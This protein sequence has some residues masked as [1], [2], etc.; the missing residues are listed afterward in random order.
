MCGSCNGAGPHLSPIN[1]IKQPDVISDVL[2]VTEDDI[3][4]SMANNPLPVPGADTYPDA[5]CRLAYED[6]AT[7]RATP[8]ITSRALEVPAGT[9]VRVGKAIVLDGDRFSSGA[10]KGEVYRLEG[11]PQ[12]L[13][14]VV[15]VTPDGDTIKVKLIARPMCDAAAKGDTFVI[16]DDEL[17]VHVP[18]PFAY[19]ADAEFVAPVRYYWVYR[20]NYG[21]GPYRP[22]IRPHPRPPG[23]MPHP[24]SPRPYTP[25]PRPPPPG[26]RPPPPGPRPPRPL[27]FP[28]GPGPVR[29]PRRRAADVTAARA[30]SEM[31]PRRRNRIERREARRAAKAQAKAARQ[32]Q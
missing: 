12:V 9:E 15:S 21:P 14:Y 8:A 6:D 26:L 20:P 22:P 28:S 13:F 11:L 27:P 32:M 24:P 4:A 1:F 18:E 7:P 30:M 31:T 23:P 29:P 17:L 16:P 5:R 25:G 3:R 2:V 19:C 10:R